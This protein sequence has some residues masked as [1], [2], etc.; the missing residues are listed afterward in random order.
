MST[1]TDRFALKS[2]FRA[3]AMV[4]M[5]CLAVALAGCTSLPEGQTPSPITVTVRPTQLS[6][7]T[8][9]PASPPVATPRPPATVSQ[10]ATPLPESA[11]AQPETASCQP[12]DDPQ[13]AV[14]DAAQARSGVLPVVCLSGFS[15]DSEVDLSLTYPDGESEDYTEVTAEDGTTVVDWLADLEAPPGTYTITAVQEDLY[16]TADVEVEA[17]PETGSVTPDSSGELAEPTIVVNSTGDS[18]SDF[19]VMLS[20]FKPN[21]E[22]PLYL[23][24]ATDEEW[25]DSWEVDAFSEVVDAQGNATFSLSIPPD[26]YPS[27][28]FALGYYV[29]D[30]TLI[31]DVFE[32]W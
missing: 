31:Y 30:E 32:S 15:A 13:V 29:D 27:P 23:Y 2:A 26:E 16:A 28:W 22:V 8:A 17:A 9:A 21:Q 1:P 4:L 12:T 19:E 20:G 10:L 25:S 14:M 18:G 6:G 3:T 11:A 5:I 24:V 7:G